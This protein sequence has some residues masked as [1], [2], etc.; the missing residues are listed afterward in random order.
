VTVS[1]TW[2]LDG[3]YRRDFS[4]FAGVTNDVYTSD[5]GFI[6]AGGLVAKRP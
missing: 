4:L 2:S 5:T 6:T 1:P 3:G